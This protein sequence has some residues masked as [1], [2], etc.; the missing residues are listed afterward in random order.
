MS[1]PDVTDS[2]DKARI[3]I[4]E[5]SLGVARALNRTLS[6]PQ[7]G[8]HWVEIRDSGEAALE[9]LR[10]AHFDLLITDLRLPGMNGLA[11]LEHARQISPDTRSILI[12]A[13]GSPLVEGRARQLA[14]AYLPKPFHLHDLIQVVRRVLSEPVAQKQPFLA[15]DAVRRRDAMRH[16]ASGITTVVDQRKAAYLK[17]L[18]CDLDHTLAESGLV[19]PETWQTLRQARSD[20]IGLTVVLVTSR[21]LE[22]YAA[23]VPYTEDEATAAGTALCDAVVAKNG[24]TV[25]FTRDDAVV[26]MSR[27]ASLEHDQEDANKGAGLRYALRELGYSPRNVVACGDAENDRS[28]FEMSEL[29]VATANAPPDVQA[30]ADVV[31][32][33]DYEAGLQALVA[34]LQTGRIPDYLPRPNRRL[35]LGHRMGGAPV[36]VDSLALVNSNMGIFGASNNRIG[37]ISR[38][39]SSLAEKLSRQGYQICII[40]LKGSYRSLW[41]DPHS[42]RLGGPETL[43]PPTTDVIDF[44]RHN[45]V[46][47]VLDLSTYTEADRT[48]Y[49]KELLPAL[50][51]LRARFGRPHW[52]SIEEAHSLCPPQER[53]LSDLL[54]HSLQA[55]GFSLVSDHPSQ[56]T[57]A[58]LKTLDCWLVTHLS[59]PEETAALGPFL[60][61]HAGGP[62]ALSQLPSLSADQAYLCLGDIEQP[63]LSAKGFIKLGLKS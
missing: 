39:A 60:T 35:L 25:Y 36:H 51:Q 6:L 34:D 63:S 45:Q 5:D 18:A 1:T 4:I 58:I 42:Q 15:S 44:C 14:N 27:T 9:R 56:I 53:Q 33:Q 32:P 2:T 13:F 7:G 50:Q 26:E 19:A 52:C 41:T 31:L 3:L 47:L 29:A 54:L 40:D 28:L 23:D 30:L 61:Q 43:L 16:G 57:P 11:V 17:V 12:T 22:S 55:G 38:L 46:N 59:Q 49:L 37:N 10:G 20:A 24:A 48:A 8:G 62:A 21:T